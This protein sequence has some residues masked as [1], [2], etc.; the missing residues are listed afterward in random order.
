[1]TK[2]LAPHVTITNKTGSAITI[3]L[4]RDRAVWILE[5][6]ERAM[7]YRTRRFDGSREIIVV[8]ETTRP[9]D[10]CCLNFGCE[11]P[12]VCNAIGF[13]CGDPRGH[14]RHLENVSVKQLQKAK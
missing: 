8:A 14:V 11:N 6:N 3:G 1:M 9:S 13:S 5:P 12:D 7:I 2:K 10:N 4:A